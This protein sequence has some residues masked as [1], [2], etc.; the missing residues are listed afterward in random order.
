MAPNKNKKKPN[1]VGKT[2]PATSSAA[3]RKPNT[4]LVLPA[5]NN[6]TGRQGDR[7]GGM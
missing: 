3:F 5:R 2:A 1:V 7:K 4:K 6:R